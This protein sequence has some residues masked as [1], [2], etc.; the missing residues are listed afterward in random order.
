MNLIRA[1]NPATKYVHIRLKEFHMA[2]EPSFQQ[3]FP[4]SSATAVSVT[5]ASH[6]FIAFYGEQMRE[7]EETLNNF[8]DNFWNGR[9]PS[10][11]ETQTIT[12]YERFRR[13]RNSIF[14]RGEGGRVLQRASWSFWR[15]VG[16]KG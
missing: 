10:L 2:P 5:S 14:S 16:Y 1:R 15:W 11:L 7:V 3:R 9:S 4:V 6:Q 8:V 13:K 12:K